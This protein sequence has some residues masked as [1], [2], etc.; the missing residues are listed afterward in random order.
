MPWNDIWQADMNESGLL[1]LIKKDRN[2]EIDDSKGYLIVD[3]NPY[4]HSKRD[5]DPEK[6]REVNVLTNVHIKK[7][8]SYNLIE[9]L[10]DNY[11]ATANKS[12]NFD[13]KEIDE[14]KE[15]LKYAI[16]TKP[17]QIAK[18]YIE[19]NYDIIDNNTSDD[20]WMKKLYDIWFEP[21]RNGSTSVFEH[22]F[23][24][25]QSSHTDTVLDGHHFWYNYYLHDGPYEVTH[26]EDTI[27]FLRYV[28]V[29]SHEKSNYA[30]VITISY[31]YTEKNQDDQTG[32]KLHKETGG[33]FVG[34]SAEGLLAIGTIAY[35]MALPKNSDRC[36]DIKKD[37][38][39]TINEETY[40][41]RVILKCDE[42]KTFFRTFYPMIVKTRRHH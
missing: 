21:R 13:P 25:E 14:I 23:V 6:N 39:I 33:F 29:E 10:L 17:M 15:F 26:Y 37:I 31:D 12:E 2:N 30:E 16:N 22:V 11:I 42:G 4:D 1:P 3:L 34:L 5:G 20:E 38:S 27:Y 32:L 18:K 24:G 28:Q 36:G 9:K 8:T 40:N 35:F 7:K 19:N 41:L